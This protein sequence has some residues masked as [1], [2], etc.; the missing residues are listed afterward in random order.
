MNKTNIIHFSFSVLCFFV[1]IYAIFASENCLKP[2]PMFFFPVY[3]YVFSSQRELERK[4]IIP[5]CL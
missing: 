2:N 3:V 1:I 4:K 5:E